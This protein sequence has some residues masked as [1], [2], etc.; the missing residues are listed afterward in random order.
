MITVLAGGVGAARFLQGVLC[1]RPQPEITVIS[2]TGDDLEF[3]GLHVSPDVDIVTYTLAGQ[4]DEARGFGI[5]NDST[6]VVAALAKLGNEHW[7]NL[8]DR[9][10]ATA[11]H[12]TMRLAQGASLTEVAGEI[13]HAFGLQIRLLPMS[14]QPVR[15]RI[16]TAAGSLAFQDYFV[17]RR[18]QD[19]VLGIEFE[20]IEAATPAPGVIA[21]INDAEAVLLAPSN[22]FVS[23][24]PI[25]ALPG[26][27]EALRLR[28]VNCVAVSPIVGGETIKGPAARMMQTLGFEN[29]AWQVADLYRDFVGTM[30]MDSIDAGLAGRIELLGVRAIVTDTIMRGIYEKS[31]LARTVLDAAGS[32]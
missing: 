6:N 7:F 12:R 21:A 19:D 32:P 24:G 14:N 18:Q 17:R 9:D 22:P 13:A 8:G 3:F 16:R 26:V 10:L 29:S 11:L 5:L 1:H 4:I 2:N 23:I 27:R 20:G 15:T 25:L 28:R 30:V 31:A